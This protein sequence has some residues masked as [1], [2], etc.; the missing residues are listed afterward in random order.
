[1]FETVRAQKKDR[2]VVITLVYSS[3]SRGISKFGGAVDF[4]EED[5]SP[6]GTRIMLS[7]THFRPCL[8]A[9]HGFLP[10]KLWK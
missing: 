1:M 7:N 4:F 6:G 3:C 2:N 8:A 9:L 5:K 10:T